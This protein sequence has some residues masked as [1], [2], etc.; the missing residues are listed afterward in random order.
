VNIAQDQRDNFVH[1]AKNAFKSALSGVLVWRV[2]SIWFFCSLIAAFAGPF[3]TYQ[4]RFDFFLIWLFLLG[5]SILVAYNVDAFCRA[6]MHRD[7]S[8]S[9]RDFVFASIASILIG[10]SIDLFLT[11]VFATGEELRPAMLELSAFTMAIILFMFALRAVIPAAETRDEAKDVLS[12][13]VMPPASL[14]RHSRLA[15]RLEI[16]KD[17]R[18][19]HITA[20]G[21]FVEVRT[22]S[23]TYRTRMR[24][25]DA[26]NELDRAIGLTVHRSHWVHRDAIQGWVPTARKPYVLLENDTRIPVSKTYLERVLAANLVELKDLEDALEGAD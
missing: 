1:K 9:F 10:L 12:T 17:A 11:H 19:I 6:F 23:E 13:P 21:H 14:P 18:I 2:I 4:N 26:V 3:G 15:K 24:F 20:K 16:P 22:N 25:S 8:R 5:F 7:A